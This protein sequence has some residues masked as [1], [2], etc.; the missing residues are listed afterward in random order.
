MISL[1]RLIIVILLSAGLI[2]GAQAY[3]IT[4][5]APD[6]VTIGSPLIITGTTTFPEDS[7]FDIVLFYSKYT[8]GEVKRQTVIVDQ[9]KEFRA[10]FE[11]RGLEKGQY[12]VEIHSIVSQGNK[13]VENSLGSSSTIRRIVRLIDRS[14]EIVIESQKEQRLPAALIVSGRVKKSDTGVLTLRAFGP[15]DFTYGPLQLI[16][17]Q[18]STDKDGHFETLI[19][20]SVPGDYQISISDKNGFIGEFPFTVITEPMGSEQEEV[21]TTVPTITDL[22]PTTTMTQTP[23][24]TDKQTPLSGTFVIGGIITGYYLLNKKRNN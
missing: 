10:G 6:S 4:I 2:S 14:D 20:V 15:E 9:T 5:D 11:T 8:A 18:G 24:P 3:I 16:T 22:A 7:Y 23:H 1:S 13:F 21:I 17:T 19:L 12:K